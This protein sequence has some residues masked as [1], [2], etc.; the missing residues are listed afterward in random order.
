MMG[1]ETIDIKTEYRSL[2]N[3]IVKEF[4]EPL[5][6]NSVLYRRAVGFFSSSALIELSRGISGL[7]KNGGKIR[8][9]AS[10]RLSVED[11]EAIS[12]GKKKR[13]E[14]IN[15]CLE[16]SI[17]EPVDT[18][19]EERLN[20][21]VNLIAQGYMDI[22][23]AIC[24]TESQ[25]GMYH[26][27]MGIM[28]DLQGN[29]VAFTG[30]MNESSNAFRS[31]YESIDV[32]CSW[33]NESERVNI[34]DRNFESLWEN[35]VDALRV[36]E[37]P[38]VV[39]DKL[40]RF[41]KNDLIDLEIDARDAV[42]ESEANRNDD[43]LRV[44]IE[45][46]DYQKE[47]ISEWRN[48]GYRGIL[49]MATG[50]GKTITSLAGMVDLYY[51]KKEKLAVVIVCPFQHLVE[52]WLEDLIKFNVLPIVGY[53]GDNYAGYLK[54]LRTKIINYNRKEKDFFCFI[55]T[56]ATFANPKVQSE[57]NNILENALLIVDEAH[58]LGA[59]NLRKCL[60]DRFD[61]RLALSA[62]IKRHWDK[63]GTEC[64]LVYFGGIA[65]EYS[66][67]RAIAEGKL[68]QYKY[69]PIFTALTPDEYIEY[70]NI[71]SEIKKYLLFDENGETK[72]SDKA[73]LLLIQRAR[74]IAGSVAKIEAMLT[75]I[76]AYA[77]DKHMLIYCGAT[78]IMGQDGYC[79][80]EDHRQIEYVCQKL[81]ERL[82][83]K[84][85]TFTSEE[86]AETRKQLL[87]QFDEG[88][89]LQALVAIKCLDEGVNV[90]SMKTAFV[91]ASSTNP[92][93]YIQRRGR[94]L[95]RSKGKDFAEI[96]DF[97]SLPCSVEFAR[98]T[99]H[100]FS[101]FDSALINRELKRVI[102]YNRLAMNAEDNADSICEVIK[103]FN[104]KEDE[105]DE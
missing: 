66:I 87:K 96:Y 91:L 104:Y 92:K 36:I 94:L 73:K 57:L 64:L 98:K 46:F 54:K 85:A 72:L 62:T 80:Y 81:S 74:V 4:Y 93:E 68:T 8:L 101:Q 10:P 40:M 90:P 49:S 84:V 32:F 24:E 69:Y 103:L 21:I 28:T 100:N 41:R 61:Y 2:A 83:M 43:V 17:Q 60:T 53:S 25:L 12:V 71:S 11:I 14:I 102:E 63:V 42:K 58:Y 23:I 35:Q 44:P 67:E 50:S 29:M 6:S 39:M 76:E 59:E 34:K 51:A 65:Y 20:L 18:F 105:E 9:I 19:E 75:Q 1:F 38:Q 78:N 37:F 27:K 13:E 55:C 56:N 30:S 88:T 86:S 7:I 70:I 82:G 89:D 5:L 16:N 48:Q 15:Q 79:D 97:I 99:E 31:N 47:A 77:N 3:D 95:R 52:Q 26:E 22:K 33:K 45:L